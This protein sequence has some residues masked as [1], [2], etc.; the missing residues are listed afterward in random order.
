M[1]EQRGQPTTLRYAKQVCFLAR[2]LA[3]VYICSSI[4]IRPSSVIP[5]GNLLLDGIT[6]AA[7]LAFAS[8]AGAMTSQSHAAG[9]YGASNIRQPRVARLPAP[10]KIEHVFQIFLESSDG[11]AWP[12]SPEFCEKRSCQ[13]IAPEFNTAEHMTPFFSSLIRDPNT[14]F[15]SNFKTR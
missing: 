1:L 15:T 6:T 14:Y 5:V 3:V 10:R 8:S 12:F 11:L 2:F 13:D 7:G 4:F 9:L